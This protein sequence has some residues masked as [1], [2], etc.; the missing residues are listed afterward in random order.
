M[1]QRRQGNDNCLKSQN[2]FYPPMALET[3]GGDRLLTQWMQ[4]APKQ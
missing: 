2:Q 4:A 3:R 1:R